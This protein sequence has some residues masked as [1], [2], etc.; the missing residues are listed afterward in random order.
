MSNTDREPDGSEGIV[1]TTPEQE[2]KQARILI[3]ALLVV[4]AL[5][6][7]LVGIEVTHAR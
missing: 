2:R 7:A 6:A 4:I 5:I 3:I 1:K